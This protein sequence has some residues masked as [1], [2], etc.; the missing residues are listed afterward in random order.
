MA[1]KEIRTEIIVIPDTQAGERVDIALSALSCTSL[2]RN[3]IKE[4]ISSGLIKRNS[5]VP[6]K[7]SQKVQNQEHYTIEHPE[8]KALE[9]TPLDLKLSLSFEDEHLAVVYKPAG[10]SVHPSDTENGPTL[11]HGLLHELNTLSS[12][13]GVARPG[14]VHR[15][16][17]GTSGLLVITKTDVAHAGLSAQFKAHTVSRKYLA[18][19]YGNLSK[20]GTSGKIDT[21]YGRHPIHRKKMT[22]KILKSTRRAITNWKIVQNFSEHLTLV[23]C[24]LE[25]GRTHQIR[26]HLAELNY[27]LVG[28]PLYGN[29][30]PH[31]ER[32]KK[33]N[34]TAYSAIKNLDHQLLHAAELGFLHPVTNKNLHFKCSLPQDFQDVI[35]YL[36][37]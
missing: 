30:G 24:K 17:K 36:H 26:V 7:A 2:S 13:G 23:E 3:Q 34:K 5:G 6:V 19:V 14:I 12:I 4:R 11:V 21:L 31:L 35:G 20:I 32:L 27:P 9:L 16:D 15:I 25:T 22:G 33:M 10:L 28:D 1:N 18:L 29:A 37:G 8:T